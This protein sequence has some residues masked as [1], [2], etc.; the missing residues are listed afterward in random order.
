MATMVLETATGNK[1]RNG[2]G[3]KVA[4][5]KEDNGKS[6]KNNDN[7]NKEPSP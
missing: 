1:T 6:G 4:G 3:N 7:G 2:N 5:N